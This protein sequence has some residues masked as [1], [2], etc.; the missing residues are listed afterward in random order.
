MFILLVSL[1]SE[2]LKAVE[3]GDVG[4]VEEL[5][6]RGANPNTKDE[7]GRTPLHYAA[8]MGHLDIAKLLLERGADP[9]ARDKYGQTPAN[10]ARAEGHSEVAELIESWAREGGGAPVGLEGLKLLLTPDEKD[11]FAR[12]LG[13]GASEVEEFI[14]NLVGV[15]IF[16]HYQG[17]KPSCEGVQI[18]REFEDMNMFSAECGLKELLALLR[19]E[20]VVKIERVPRVKALE[21]TSA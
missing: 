10:V 7:K 20:A 3:R 2:L 14:K 13:V 8:A 18:I 1:D 16:V 12:K 5:L 19:D 17:R 4:K 11:L 6:K 15:R 9:S 21:E